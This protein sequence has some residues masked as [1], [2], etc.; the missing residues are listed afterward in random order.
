MLARLLHRARYRWRRGLLE[1]LLLIGLYALL[2][3]WL[4]RD[5]ASGPVPPLAGTTL[6]GRAFDLRR[7]SGRPVLVHFWASWCRICA[8]EQ[9]G[10]NA[11]ARDWPVITVAMQSGSAAD[12][13]R[14]LQ[15]AGLDF[16]VL[17]DPDGRI[18]RRFGVVAVPASFVV[19]ARNHIAFRERGYTSEAGL[20]FRLWLA[21]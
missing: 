15:Q 20:R 7:Y 2:H 10:I 17:N 8:L 1:A 14:H 18:A 6:D 5:M 21:R 13:R 9:D 11:I 3:A 12:V 16:P 4:Q 19:D